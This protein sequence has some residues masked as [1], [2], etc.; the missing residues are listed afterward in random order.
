MAVSISGTELHIVTPESFVI[1]VFERQLTANVADWRQHNARFNNPCFFHLTI[2]G[3][4]SSNV[5][6]HSFNKDQKSGV[7]ISSLLYG[8]GKNRGKETVN[9][10]TSG[11]D[12]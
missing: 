5:R 3:L 8:L 6:R 10:F 1:E 11:R 7:S 2:K 9:I 12:L 4:M